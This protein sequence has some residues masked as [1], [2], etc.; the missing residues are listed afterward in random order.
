MGLAVYKYAFQVKYMALGYGAG[1]RVK[2]RVVGS[3]REVLAL[4]LR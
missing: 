3:G 1:L 4:T 2:V